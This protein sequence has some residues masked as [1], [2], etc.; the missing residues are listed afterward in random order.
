LL[1]TDAKAMQHARGRPASSPPHDVFKPF[2]ER[3]WCS[4]HRLDRE[5][6]MQ[7]RT[8]AMLMLGAMALSAAATAQ[9]APAPPA[10]TRTTVAATKLPTVTDAPLHFRAVSVT[11]PAG[12]TSSVSLANGILYQISG[13]TEVA[14]ETG[15]KIVNAGEGLFI[16]GGKPAKL[17]AGSGGPSASSISSWSRLRIWIGLSRPNRRP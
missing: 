13:S 15:T 4:D 2:A 9:P 16:P 6:N 11:L 3:V 8:T 12:E 17:K 5:A 14:L 10:I 1:L 7:F